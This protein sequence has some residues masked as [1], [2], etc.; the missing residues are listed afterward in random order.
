MIFGRD[1]I[2]KADFIDKLISR[3]FPNGKISILDIGCG[4]GDILNALRGKN[5]VLFGIDK[6]ESM[7]KYAKKEFQG[8]RF[9]VG[10][11][12]NLKLKEK[13]DVVLCIFST[14][15]YNTTDDEIHNTLKGFNTVLKNEGILVLDLVNFIGMIK[16]KS[17]K[18][19]MKKSYNYER[20]KA[21]MTITNTL[22][23][24][25]QAVKSEWV[26]LVKEAVGTKFRNYTFREKTTFRMFFPRE[27]E[28][29]LLSHGFKVKKI[30][31]DY[32]INAENL[33]GHR[34]IIVAEKFD[35]GY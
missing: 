5:R 30:F 19:I 22:L 3:Y 34:M 17:F 2:K 6:S 29:L 27:L 23:M 4:T 12:T 8:I 9:D 16:D 35:S 14:F 21:K 18:K 13:F 33:H 26:W 32:K 24:D 25:Q 20:L 7:I 31:S 15:M 28:G 10:D 1:N 11:M